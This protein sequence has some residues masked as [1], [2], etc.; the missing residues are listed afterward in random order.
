RPRNSF[1]IYRQNRRTEV[2]AMRPGI[3]DSQ[4]SVILGEM[5]RKEKEEVKMLYRDLANEEK[6]IHSLKYP[7]YKYQ[8][9]R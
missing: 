4:V 3:N 6:R 2:V 7:N 9:K 1:M 5:W 8:P